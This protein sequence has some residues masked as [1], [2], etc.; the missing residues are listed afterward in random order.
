VT[1]PLHGG[2]VFGSSSQLICQ[3]DGLAKA[4]DVVAVSVNH[5]LNVFG[6][7]HL[8]DVMGSQF[9]TFGTVGMQDLELA[10]ADP[11]A[12]VRQA[13]EAL[14]QGMNFRG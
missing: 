3:G 9:A 14:P 12:Q 6:Y 11:L 4:G 10:L 1:R 8:G 5:R 2:Y 13:L 7:L